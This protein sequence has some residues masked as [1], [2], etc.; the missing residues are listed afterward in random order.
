MPLDVQHADL[1]A[2]QALLQQKDDKHDSAL[3]SAFEHHEYFAEEQYD[4]A[5]Y[6][7]HV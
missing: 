6:V 4:A 5:P 2:L 3:R 7:I 1:A